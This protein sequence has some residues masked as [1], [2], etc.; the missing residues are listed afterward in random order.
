M[1]G[2]CGLRKTDSQRIEGIVTWKTGIAR[3][4]CHVSLSCTWEIYNV[5]TD[6]S[7]IFVSKHSP[8]LPLSVALS[9]Q[10]MLNVR[11]QFFGVK[12]A[13]LPHLFFC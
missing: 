1:D 12:N 2:Q 13:C 6:T 3:L 4:V 5:G 10:L 9:L 7:H 11:A 8:R